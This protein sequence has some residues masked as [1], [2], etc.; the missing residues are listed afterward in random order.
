MHI[1]I[2]KYFFKEM[3]FNFPLFNH[4]FFVVGY[5]SGGYL[6]RGLLSGGIC[7]S[8]G[9][10]QMCRGQP[11]VNGWGICQSRPGKKTLRAST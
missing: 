3:H 11:Q 7:L 8:G 9:I 6:V 4:F 2:Y 1:N 5:I 10:D